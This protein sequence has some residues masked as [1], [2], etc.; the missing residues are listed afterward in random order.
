MFKST[1]ILAVR[2]EDH[3]VV[4]GDGQVTFNDV[5][6]SVADLLLNNPK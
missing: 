6:I 3:V 1:T 5:V 2:N 4:A